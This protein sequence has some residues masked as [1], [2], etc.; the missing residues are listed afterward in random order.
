MA[1]IA[2]DGFVLHTSNQAGQPSR[3][4]TDGLEGMGEGGQWEGGA[5]RRGQE[6]D[7]EEMGECRA[8]EWGGIA[9]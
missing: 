2:W 9:G 1:A 7:R 3:Y 5:R 6:G 8:G 4:C